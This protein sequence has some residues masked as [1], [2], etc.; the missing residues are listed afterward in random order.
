MKAYEK[1]EKQIVSAFE[2]KS[3]VDEY[4]HLLEQLKENFRK[5]I[6]KK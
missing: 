1:Y 5:L 4:S 2:A 6:F 3:S